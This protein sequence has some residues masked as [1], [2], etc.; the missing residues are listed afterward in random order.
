MFSWF[1]FM[2]KWGYFLIDPQNGKEALLAVSKNQP[3]IMSIDQ[4]RSDYAKAVKENIKHKTKKKISNYGNSKYTEY[5]SPLNTWLR[6]ILTAEAQGDLFSRRSYQ[7][8]NKRAPGELANLDFENRQ[9]LCQELM[10]DP[11]RLVIKKIGMGQFPSYGN[12]TTRYVDKSHID[13]RY[14]V[15]WTDRQG[16]EQ[17]YYFAS[18]SLAYQFA[19]DLLNPPDKEE[20]YLLGFERDMKE[21]SKLPPPKKVEMTR[22]DRT[23][24]DER[25]WVAI[26]KDD[27]GQI[28][29]FD[30]LND[31]DFSKLARLPGGNLAFELRG[32]DVKD[33]M[34]SSLSENQLNG[35]RMVID[36]KSQLDDGTMIDFRLGGDS[37]S[38][39]LVEGEDFGEYEKNP[40]DYIDQKFL[41]EERSP[42]KAFTQWVKNWKDE[43][44][45][46]G[47]KGMVD[48]A[49]DQLEKYEQE[50]E[51][52]FHYP[53]I[54][55]N[56]E[57]KSQIQ[58]DIWNSF[59]LGTLDDLMPFSRQYGVENIF[60]S[61]ADPDYVIDTI[62]QNIQACEQGLSRSQC[63]L[64][65][66][67]KIAKHFEETAEKAIKSNFG[68]S[69]K[70][71]EMRQQNTYP[72]GN[73]G[74]P[75]V[76]GFIGFA[77][78][79]GIGRVVGKSGDTPNEQNDLRDGFQEVEGRFGLSK[80][81]R[82]VRTYGDKKYYS[83]SSRNLVLWKTK[84]SAQRIAKLNRKNGWLVRTVKVNPYGST[85][86]SEKGYWVNLVAPDNN[87]IQQA[88]AKGLK[89]LSKKH[90]QL[91]RRL[92]LIRDN[93]FRQDK[94][95]YRKK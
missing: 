24:Y 70:E 5:D 79:N 68:Q 29:I 17:D 28:L 85:D 15:F 60:L 18:H 21:F 75:G 19:D 69:V 94:T 54:Y 4:A 35:Y 41:G 52:S 73:R 22:L 20:R 90:Q 66:E 62:F 81:K 49:L 84:E 86:D 36:G 16:K 38:G 42:I 93:G 30:D 50:L 67:D 78:R 77:R 40:N 89:N 63:F 7:M 88:T 44:F 31:V 82:Y 72:F 48:T 53:Y 47:N 8:F 61:G 3:Q 10:I 59:H 87:A 11:S 74:V 58:Y 14:R 45:T 39:I 51:V 92:N 6:S 43:F 56:T 57:G 27:E 37:K 13:A 1:A 55:R 65:A 46:Y 64:D 95:Y 80:T 12:T 91:Q 83:N 26:S 2:S 9:T 76:E 33:A 71:K 32:D 25:S 34:E 23:D